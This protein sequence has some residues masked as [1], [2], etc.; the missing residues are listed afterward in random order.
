MKLEN[1]ILET[2]STKYYE[3]LFNYYSYN[4]EHLEPWE[5]T[6]ANNYYT[7]NFH[8]QR[9]NNRIDLINK[10]KSMHFIL[11]N[12]IRTEIIGVCNYTD[13]KNRECWLGYSISK[14]Y[15]GKGYMYEALKNTNDYMFEE[16]KIKKI[17]AGIIIRNSRS[18]KL[19][20]CLNFKVNGNHKE[21]EINGNIE[22]LEIYYLV[23]KPQT[24]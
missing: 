17:N 6:R 2:I 20:N 23:N 18:I 3:L 16:F 5:P 8:I 21:L 10:N 1:F 12:N 13:I 4:K 9:I 24:A 22:K 11:L 14:G 19:I 7:L 15:E